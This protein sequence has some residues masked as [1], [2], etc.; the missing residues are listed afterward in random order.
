MFLFH[1]IGRRT[2]P[3]GKS[4]LPFAKAAADGAP[5]AINVADRF[6]IVKNL[7][8]ALQLLLARC[9]EEIKATS[10]TPEPNQD[11]PSKPVIT[12]EEWRPSEPAHVQKSRLTRRSGRSVR[13]QQVVALRDQGMKPKEIARQLGMGERTVHRWLA[14]GTFPQARKRRKRDSSCD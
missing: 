1:S 10:Q 13:Y 5:Q 8:E 3:R 2:L 9:Q 4:Y 12:L 11:K 6:H 14:S 7:T